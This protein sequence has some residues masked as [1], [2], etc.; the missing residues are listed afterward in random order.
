MSCPASNF[1]SSHSDSRQVM[2]MA[3]VR[4]SFCVFAVRV[5]SRS[6][7][8]SSP[9]LS[10]FTRNVC[11]SLRYPFLLVSHH[12]QGG[13][14]RSRRHL[15]PCIC[16]YGLL[17]LCLRSTQSFRH[18][19]HSSRILGILTSDT[20]VSLLVSYSLQHKSPHFTPLE[21]NAVWGLVRR[22]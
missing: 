12:I 15:T 5:D 4:L 9:V 2:W 7:S 16:S 21:L 13:R 6:S 14:N 22:G 8:A 1:V 20:S 11:P 10:R 19:R 3:L 17:A 18:R